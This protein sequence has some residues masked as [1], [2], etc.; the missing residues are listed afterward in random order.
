MRELEQ[1]LDAQGFESE[2]A[3]APLAQSPVEMELLRAYAN[4][5]NEEA[6][7]QLVARYVDL[8]YSSALRQTNS[9]ASAQDITQS[10]FIILARKAASLGRHTV[11]SGWLFRAVRYAVLD[12]H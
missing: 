10:V 7:A 8:V 1:T 4:D 12:A 2:E 3:A 6:F 5:Q 11:L 9:H